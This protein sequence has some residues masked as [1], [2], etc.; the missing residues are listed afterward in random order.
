MRNIKILAPIL[1]VVSVY[2]LFS[3]DEIL[4]V[5][6][7]KKIEVSTETQ[8]IEVV[9][10]SES[11]ISIREKQNQMIGSSSKEAEVIIA[12][13]E[14]EIDN[15]INEFNDNLLQKDK[16]VELEKKLNEASVEYKKAVLDKVNEMKHY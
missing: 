10:E 13:G 15:L 14:K 11:F 7:K 9:S 1:I 3:G 16:Q 8:E 12:E 4:D 2:Y 5:K 6:E